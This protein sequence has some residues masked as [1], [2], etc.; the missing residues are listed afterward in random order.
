MF[1]PSD[2]I[3]SFDL[4][5]NRVYY[6]KNLALRD[7]DMFVNT[8]EDRNV[9]IRRTEIEFVWVLSSPKLKN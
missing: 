5:L 4:I 1:I 8:A 9:V 7:R 6:L 2:T 3:S